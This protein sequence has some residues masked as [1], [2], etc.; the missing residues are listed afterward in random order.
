MSDWQDQA[1]IL[2][3]RPHGESAAL[4]EVFSHQQGRHNGILRGGMGRRLMPVIQPGNLVQAVW[5]SRIKD[6]LGTFTFEPIRSRAHAME[7]REALSGLTA[8]CAMLQIV[9][10]E[11]APHPRLWMASNDLLERIL[12]PDWPSFY[13]EWEMLLLQELGFGLD[14]TSC[15]VTGQADDLAY[16]SPKTG[17]AVS[18]KGAGPWADRLLKLPAQM[19]TGLVARQNLGEAFAITS[20]FLCREALELTGRKDLPEARGRFL[21]LLARK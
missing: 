2:S 17:R 4:V 9:L 1:L 20:H 12:H 6:D 13:L 3:S 19:G 5:R 11:R 18:Q 14:L 15:A 10:P 8:L 21:D 16:V 7:S